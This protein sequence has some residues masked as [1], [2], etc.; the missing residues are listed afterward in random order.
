MADARSAASFARAAVA[1]EVHE[2]DYLVLL[3]DRITTFEAMAFRLP[4]AADLE[5]YLK[6]VVRLKAVRME[7]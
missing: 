7:T 5:D 3:A 2:S 1:F 4:T 6:E